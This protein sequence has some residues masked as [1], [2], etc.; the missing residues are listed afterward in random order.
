MGGSGGRCPNPACSGPG[1]TK[2]HG[3][4]A[5]VA[6]LRG[7]FLRTEENASGPL[8]CTCFHVHDGRLR[9][10]IRQYGLTTVLQVTEM[11]RGCGGCRTC[12]PDVERILG[13]EASLRAGRGTKPA[14]GAK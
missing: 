2:P 1:M 7:L 9:R 10:A 4:E 3:I 6:A 11:T 14:E 13:E 12:R 8:I 5:A